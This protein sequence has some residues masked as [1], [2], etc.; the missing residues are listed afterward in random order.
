MFQRDIEELAIA[1]RNAVSKHRQTGSIVTRRRVR[2]RRRDFSL[3]F[4]DHPGF[5]NFAPERTESDAWDFQDCEKFQ[6]SVIRELE[7]FTSVAAALGANALDK[8]RT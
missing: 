7:E 1:I 5:A 8:A 3:V 2:V 6:V 4:E